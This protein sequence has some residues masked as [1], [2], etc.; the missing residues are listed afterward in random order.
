MKKS[1][2][3]LFIFLMFPLFLFANSLPEGCQ[4][5]KACTIE[6][7]QSMCADGSSSYV[8]VFI[9]K[10][11]PSV[12]IYL[13]PGGACWNEKTCTAGYVLKLSRREP[14]SD[15]H[16]GERGILDLDNRSAP[17]F[18]FSQAT[19]PYCT[20]DVYL[21]DNVINYG[22]NL[23]KK[24]IRHQGY[25]NVLHS[26]K[27]IQEIFPHPKK[28]VLL[29]RS[30]GG[31]GVLG[32]I[33]S[34]VKTFP[35]SQKFAISDAGTPL[36]PPYVETE[37]Y[38]EVI[39]HWNALGALQKAGINGIRHF[40]DLMKYNTKHFPEVRFGF[41]QSYEDRVMQYFASAIG[42]EDPNSAVALSSLS[43]W[44]NFLGADTPHAKVFFTTG[45]SHI[46]TRKPLTRTQSGSIDL[47][48][49]L[50][51]FIN[52]SHEWDNVIP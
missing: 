24:V 31:L 49:W 14:K 26:L 21:G 1:S 18:G 5:G 2:H 27:V 50:L 30:A 52:D 22:T 45:A 47:Q 33:K 8:Q 29:G 7:P 6:V 17:L 4:Y 41:I 40:G 44:R 37:S 51:R 25:A 16:R 10:D 3:L 20:G 9:Q 43:A 15:L 36:M 46:H 11:A 12:V 32:H 39:A 35:D 13:E 28:V 23:E 42:S 38:N 34:L 48:E 19:I